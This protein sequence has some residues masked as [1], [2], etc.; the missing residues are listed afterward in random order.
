MFDLFFGIVYDIVKV[1]LIIIGSCVFYSGWIVMVYIIVFF[2][3]DIGNMV[4]YVNIFILVN[5]VIF[6]I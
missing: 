3:G 2:S 6:N 5:Y 4:I 1:M